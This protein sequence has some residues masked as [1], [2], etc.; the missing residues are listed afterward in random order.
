MRDKPSLLQQNKEVFV[1]K[2]KH[3]KIQ[4]APYTA[5]WTGKQ[6]DAR[7]YPHSPHAMY[8]DRAALGQDKISVVRC[9]EVANYAVLN[10]GRL[11]EA[12]DIRVLLLLHSEQRYDICEPASQC[13]GEPQFLKGRG[14]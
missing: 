2:D 7:E 14:S 5:D 3:G 8:L 6:E 11:D 4:A 13:S 9:G 12:R 10:A 1:S